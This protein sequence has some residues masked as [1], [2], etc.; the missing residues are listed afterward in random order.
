MNDDQKQMDYDLKRFD[1]EMYWSEKLIHA[2]V[3]I[4]AFC[5]CA[6]LG[7]ICHSGFPTS[8]LP[9]RPFSRSGL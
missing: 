6:L 4:V 5:A 9:R 1:R 7:D 3:K 2:P 8:E